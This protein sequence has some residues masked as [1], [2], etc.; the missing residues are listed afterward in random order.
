MVFVL[1]TLVGVTLRRRA[2][3]ASTG[4]SSTTPTPW[5]RTSPTPAASSPAPRSPTAGSRSAR[6]RRSE[7]TDRGVDVHL[8]VDND[9]DEIPADA[10][11]VVGNRSAV[12]EQYV[13]L[14]P[15][16]T[17]KPYLTEDVRDRRGGHAHPDRDRDAADQPHDH[18]RVGRQGGPAD[19]RHRARCGVRRHRGGPAADHRLGQ[20][21]H[22]GRQRQLRRH[23]RPDPR[24]QHGPARPDRLE[25]TRSAASPRTCRCSAAPW[26]GPTRTCARS[27][28]TAPPPPTSCARSSRT[29]RSTSASWSTTWSP[30]ARSSS[31]TSTASNRSS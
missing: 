7:L 17:T 15:Q 19:Q 2:T 29:T 31:S 5:S 1:I 13:E 25:E 11:A 23:H 3:P 14:Q 8:A 10:I 20:L 4:W 9:Y 28:T 6:S 21:V 16:A 22:R 24:Q 12:G 18:R 30:P 26:R 27:S